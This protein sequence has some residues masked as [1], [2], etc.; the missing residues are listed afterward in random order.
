MVTVEDCPD[1]DPTI[2][3]RGVFAKDKG[4]YLGTTQSWFAKRF[5][6]AVCKDI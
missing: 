6:D 4:H 5:F 3:T 1:W 2:P